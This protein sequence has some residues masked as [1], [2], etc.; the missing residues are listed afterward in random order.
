MGDAT[1]EF[2]K[3]V[4]E[5]LKE[6]PTCLDNNIVAVFVALGWLPGDVDRDDSRVREIIEKCKKVK[7]KIY[8]HGE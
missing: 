7:G 8:K 2:V 1:E 6:N 3:G 4:E 5:A